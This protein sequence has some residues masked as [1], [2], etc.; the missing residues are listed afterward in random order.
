MDLD[1][2]SYLRVVVNTSTRIGNQN[3]K[4][5]VVVPPNTTVEIYVNQ[6]NSNG[7]DNNQG[8]A[9]PATFSCLSTVITVSQS[10]SR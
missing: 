9:V 4:D 10:V 5:L 6:S 3:N 1:P 8:G 2:G 7:N